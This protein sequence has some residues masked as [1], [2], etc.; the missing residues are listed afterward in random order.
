MVHHKWHHFRCKVSYPKCIRTKV[1][2]TIVVVRHL[3][4]VRKTRNMK[5]ANF[6]LIFGIYNVKEH[7]GKMI[8]IL[9]R[10]PEGWPNRAWPIQPINRSLPKRVG[11]PCP[12]RSALK[13]IPVQDFNSLSIS[14]TTFLAPYIKKLETY[15]ALLCFWIF[16]P[17]EVN[18]RSAVPLIK[19]SQYWLL[20]ARTAENFSSWC[21]GFLIWTR[22]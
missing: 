8:I 4:T 13:R 18:I 17:C 10:L 15:L 14:S 3:Q 1:I 12:V 7:Y 2:S 16:A 19:K 20:R 5:R 22:A 6:F 9:L 11:W 21:E